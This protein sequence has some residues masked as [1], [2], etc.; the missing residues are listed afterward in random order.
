MI[1]A[2][3]TSGALDIVLLRLADFLDSQ[4]KIRNRV[5]SA[6]AYPILMTVIGIGV[7]SFIFTFVLLVAD[8][9]DYCRHCFLYKKKTQDS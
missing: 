8:Y 4:I 2:G 9:Y 3:E 5:R 7:L 1:M 6:L